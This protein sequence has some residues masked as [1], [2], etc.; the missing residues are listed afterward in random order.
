MCRIARL[1]SLAVIVVAA[2]AAQGPDPASPDWPQWRGPFRNAIAA[3]FVVPSRWPEQLTRRWST[4]VGL[5]YATPLLVGNRLYVF[6]R[7]ADDEVMM[8]LD[9]ATG[10]LVWRTAYPAPFTMNGSSAVVANSTTSR[11]I[12]N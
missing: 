6:A 1:G 11:M 7:Q 3:G 10:A 4:D 5:G 12:R 9:V 2:L 8:A